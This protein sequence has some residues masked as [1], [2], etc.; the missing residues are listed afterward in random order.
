MVASCF[1]RGIFMVLLVDAFFSCKA[2]KIQA[3]AVF[4]VA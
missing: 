1:L 4:A 3:V 2:G